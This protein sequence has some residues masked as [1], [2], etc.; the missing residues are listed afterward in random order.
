MERIHH[1]LTI[2]KIPEQNGGAE[3]KKRT[4]K[5]FIRSLLSEPN[6]QKRF[7]A[8]ALATSTYLINR[9]PSKTVFGMT[10]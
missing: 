4:F 5:E 9:S 7:W 8:E 3:R 10:P 6:L 1:N 2:P